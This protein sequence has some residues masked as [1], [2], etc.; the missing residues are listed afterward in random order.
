MSNKDFHKDFLIAYEDY[1]D[2]KEMM[3]DDF[4]RY[5]YKN[6]NRLSKMYIKENICEYVDNCTDIKELQTLYNKIKKQ[7]KEK[8]INKWIESVRTIKCGDYVTD[9]FD[10]L[11]DID[12]D[13]IQYEIAKELAN[14]LE[15][16]VYKSKYKNEYQ[17]TLS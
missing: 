14:I 9:T 5:C 7:K 2:N 6:H 1:K 8:Q 4:F 17:K 10:F 16:A 13:D 11:W 3:N 12:D 15:Y